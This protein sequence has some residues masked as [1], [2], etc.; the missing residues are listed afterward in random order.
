M[1]TEA[2]H[3]HSTDSTDSTDPVGDRSGYEY[4]YENEDA[5]HDAPPDPQA[6]TQ[7]PTVTPAGTSMGGDPLLT[8]ESE[9]ALLDRWTEIQVSFVEDPRGS[10]EDADALVEQVG[11]AVTAS[12]Q[13]R[14]SRLASTWRD[15]QPDTEQLRVALQQYRSFMQVVLPR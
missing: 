9:S 8:P 1:T 2:D 13:E 14:R 3:T 5:G 4:E 12:F 15:G 11:A 6:T 7:E 10:V